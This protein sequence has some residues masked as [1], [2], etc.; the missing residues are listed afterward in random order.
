MLGK[1]GHDQIMAG[2]FKK[3]FSLPCF[4]GKEC[5]V[6]KSLRMKCLPANRTEPRPK[7]M[8][9]AILL[10]ADGNSFFFARNGSITRSFNGMRINRTTTLARRSQASGNWREIEEKN[11]NII[12]HWVLFHYTKR[13]FFGSLKNQWTKLNCNIYRFMQFHR[14]FQYL[15]NCLYLQVPQY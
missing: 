5:G 11:A 12:L 15:C 4:R 2:F 9:R 14:C 3:H 6:S 8:P 10:S 13:L 7:I 1:P